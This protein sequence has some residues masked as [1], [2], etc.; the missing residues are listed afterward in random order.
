MRN[1][2]TQRRLRRLEAGHIFQ[3]DL[4]R[5]TDA[6]LYAFIR[7]GYRVLASEHGSH[8]QAVTA[9]RQ[10]G[11][12]GDLALAVI[13]EEDTAFLMHRSCKARECKAELNTPDRSR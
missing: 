3:G 9:L 5:A 7:D 11:H 4:E 8:V 12:A 2:T 10:T 6:Q 13:I 1:V